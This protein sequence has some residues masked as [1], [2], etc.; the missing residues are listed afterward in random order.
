VSDEVA[1]A[2]RS[3]HFAKSHQGDHHRTTRLCTVVGMGDAEE[4]RRPALIG[5]LG[6]EYIANALSTHKS[7]E[8]AISDVHAR[9]ALNHPRRC[10][11]LALPR[12]SFVGSLT[13]APAS[14][15]ASPCV[16][17][18]PPLRQPELRLRWSLFGG[19]SCRRKTGE[20]ARNR[21]Q[22]KNPQVDMRLSGMGSIWALLGC[23]GRAESD[24]AA[25]GGGK[26]EELRVE[27]HTGAGGGGGGR[28][29]S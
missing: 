2:G 27:W 5:S 8:A 1:D 12:V 15:P 25:D 26:R 20:C 21:T 6:S 29:R 22:P 23:D 19:S 17:C 13:Y 16:G 7:L 9:G 18:T 28:G 14:P 3:H 24:A 11:G 10:C 4:A